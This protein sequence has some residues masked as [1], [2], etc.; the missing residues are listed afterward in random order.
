ML[1]ESV[2]QLPQAIAPTR[3]QIQKL[4]SAM[5]HMPQIDIPT[6]HTFGPGFYCRTIRIPAGVTLTGKVHAT[7][8][9]FMLV[10]GELLVA[11]E[12][13]TAHLKAPAQMVCRPGLKRV[14]HALTDVVCTNVHITPERDLAKL[15][16]ALIVPDAL[17]APKTAE[18]LQ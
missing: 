13:G 18:A 17:E 11:T 4:E 9:I 7:E 8:H 5:R 6:D 3:E 10:E 12:D 1:A 16:A 15:E 14:G 2:D